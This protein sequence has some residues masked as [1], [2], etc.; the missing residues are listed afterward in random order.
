MRLRSRAAAITAATLVVGFGAATASAATTTFDV[1]V[2]GAVTN[3]CTGEAVVINGTD[4]MKFTDNSSLAG[5]KSQIEA[6]LTGV[7]GVTLMGVR[8]VMNQQT[9][10]MQH[11][12]FDPSGNV[13]LTV[14]ET[15]ILTRQGE[16]GSLLTGDDFR[17][18][19]VTHL[20]VSNGITRADKQ[21]LSADCR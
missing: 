9:S 4:H 8:Y 13:Q 18:H 7:K 14:E 6:N 21:D 10:D 19:V 16:D 15:T 3:D 5:L 20:T 17:L 11:A 2:N 12:E 1:P